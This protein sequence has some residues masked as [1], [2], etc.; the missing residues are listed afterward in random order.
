MNENYSKYLKQTH[1]ASYVQSGTSMSWPLLQILVLIN[2]SF[3]TICY[4]F[5]ILDPEMIQKEKKINQISLK[6]RGIL[7]DSPLPLI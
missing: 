4:A 6:A 3:F 5:A 7:E 1:Q 2:I